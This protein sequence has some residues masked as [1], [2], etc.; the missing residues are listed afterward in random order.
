MKIED[1]KI[2]IAGSKKAPLVCEL[3]SYGGKN[4][5]DVRKYFTDKISGELAPT[6]KGISLNRMQ[7]E[8]LIEVFREKSEIIE[9]WFDSG[10]TQ[11]EINARSLEESRLKADEYRVEISEW[12]GF[13]LSRYE[14]IGGVSVLQLNKSHPWVAT[15]L[16]LLP[17]DLDNEIF[18][19]VAFL[20]QAYH[21][22]QDLIDAKNSDA[23]EIAE[24]IE[25]NWGLHA[26]LSRR[27]GASIA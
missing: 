20:L 15:L 13:E 18:V 12:K 11:Q 25:A 21:K 5:L 7:Y 1:E 4:L 24:T 14:Q 2:L 19:H 22:S 8:A 27:G 6:K 10:A 16:N 23:R 9:S 26:K 3:S 17:D